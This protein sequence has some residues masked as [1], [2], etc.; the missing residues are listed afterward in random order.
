MQAR[1]PN[2]RIARCRAARRK[3]GLQP[4]VLL[5]PDVYDL[6]YRVRLASEYR[7]LSQLTVD[8]T[9]AADGFAFLAAQTDGWR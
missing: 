1:T 4:V 7:R 8:E 5:L 9:A 2:D 6:A 3:L